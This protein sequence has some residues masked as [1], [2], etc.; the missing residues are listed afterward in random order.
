MRSLYHPQEVYGIYESRNY[1]GHEAGGGSYGE[2]S[3]AAFKLYAGANAGQDC[4]SREGSPSAEMTA[5]TA[6][7]ASGTFWNQA[8]SGTRRPPN[9]NFCFWQA[10]YV[11]NRLRKVR[12]VPVLVWPW[13]NHV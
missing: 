10:R 13:G 3:G 9:P 11:R 8:F 12:L 1:Q 7:V 6:E 5:M 2:E 4:Y